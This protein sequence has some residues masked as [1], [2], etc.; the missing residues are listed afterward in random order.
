MTYFLFIF[1][2]IVSFSVLFNQILNQ[3][4]EIFDWKPFF[5]RWVVS[6][7]KAK[8]R[9]KYNYNWFQKAIIKILDGCP[10]CL[11]GWVSIFAYPVLFYDFTIIFWTGA[12]FITIYVTY[13][14]QTLN[15]KYGE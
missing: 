7:G 11:S 2:S 9:I 13:I 3:P 12:T 15:R 5:V 10:K 1:C 14:F 8:P 4:D 6:L